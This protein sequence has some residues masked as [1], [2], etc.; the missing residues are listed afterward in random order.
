ML[1]NLTDFWR[2]DMKLFKGMML[3][4]AAVATATTAQAADLPVAPEP[5]D[6]VR[7]CDAYGARFFY[8][9]GTETC[10]RVGGRVRADYGISDFGNSGPNSWDSKADNSLRFRA[11]GYIRLDARTQTEFGLLRTYTDV[12]FT[13]NNSNFGSAGG[14]TELWDAF[15]Q[16]GGFTFG[17]TGSFFDYWT[18][19]SW[20]SRIGQGLDSR[21][22]LAAYTATFGNGLSASLSLESNTGERSP[23]TYIGGYSRGGFR[24]PALVANV[25]VVQGWGGAQLMGVVKANR[26][27]TAPVDSETAWAIGASARFNLPM[28]GSNTGLGLRAVYADGAIGYIHEAYGS[29]DATLNAAGTGLSN[30]TGWGVAAGITHYWTPTIYTAV[31]GQYWDI[32]T[33]NTANDLSAWSAHATLGWTPVSGLVIGTEF[34][35]KDEDFGAGGV[36]NQDMTVTFRVQRTF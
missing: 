5:V 32:D 9:P 14:N 29:Y 28:L 33:L 11:R 25:N 22:N 2:S 8:I 18:G 6:Y 16:L 26:A 31:Q 27:S 34:E 3:G 12:W 21:A 35:Y 15:V 1:A 36:D 17:R 13:S 23:S 20:G 19:E 7:I 10:L 24:Y 30:S 4:A